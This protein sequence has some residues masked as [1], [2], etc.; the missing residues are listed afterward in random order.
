M[1]SLA[2]SIVD[3]SRSIF[4]IVDQLQAPLSMQPH[5][6]DAP[7]HVDDA[8]VVDCELRKW[9]DCRQMRDKS[10]M[11]LIVVDFSVSREMMRKRAQLIGLG[12]VAQLASP[13]AIVS[14]TVVEY[15]LSLP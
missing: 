10:E 6:F 13:S 11:R 14:K 7:T 8:S 3:V 15:I 1:Y 4:D 9:V 12:S 2:Q 5:A